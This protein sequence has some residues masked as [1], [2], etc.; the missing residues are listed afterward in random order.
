MKYILILLLSSIIC[1]QP[2][3]DDNRCSETS[4]P[5]NQ[6]TIRCRSG[7]RIELHQD[8]IICRCSPDDKLNVQVIDAGQ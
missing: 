2:V 5:R 6:E 3:K 4:H 1:C 8:L 7:Q